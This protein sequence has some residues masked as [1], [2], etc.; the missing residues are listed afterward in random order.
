MS[1]LLTP[2]PHPRH[3][4]KVSYGTSRLG[5]H[6]RTHSFLLPGG[7]YGPTHRFPS[8]RENIL[9]VLPARALLRHPAPG[10]GGLPSSQVLTQTTRVQFR[11]ASLLNP[12]TDTNERG[13]SGPRCRSSDE[14]GRNFVF[15]NLSGARE[16]Q[17]PRTFSFVSFRGLEG[18][19]CCSR[20][21]GSVWASRGSIR[22]DFPSSPPAKT[23]LASGRK[24]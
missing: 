11:R 23:S 16:A 5:V 17:A 13:E 1:G 22:V 19:Q 9:R 4:Q 3:F 15:S 8:L 2:Q 24:S 10:S 14:P 20:L 21:T 18:E 12:H 7:S 6:A